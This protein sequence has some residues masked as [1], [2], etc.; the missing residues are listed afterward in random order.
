MTD[1]YYRKTFK[2]TATFNKHVLPYNSNVIFFHDYTNSCFPR[3]EMMISVLRKHGTFISCYTRWSHIIMARLLLFHALTML[4][5]NIFQHLY[6]ILPGY[7]GAQH[8]NPSTDL[9]WYNFSMIIWLHNFSEMWSDILGKMLHL[10]CL[11]NCRVQWSFERYFVQ[12]IRN[13][14]G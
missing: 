13:I 10:S 14:V 9:K 2:L 5:F 7:W 3:W 4:Q 1:R 12:Y 6:M 11:E 8:S